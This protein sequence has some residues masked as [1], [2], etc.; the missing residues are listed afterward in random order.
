MAVNDFLFPDDEPDKPRMGGKAYA[1][2]KLGK[3]FP[4]PGWFVVTPQAMTDGALKSHATKALADALDSLGPGP[5]AVRSSAVDEDGSESSFAGQFES[6]LNVAAENVAQKITEVWQSAFT[7]SVLT[8]RKQRGL[9][10][11]PSAPAVLIQKMVRAESAGVAFTA[12]P[13]THDT[14]RIAIMSVKGLADRLV[15]GEENG[16][17]YY[18]D[19]KGKPLSQDLL[20]KK[21]ILTDKQKKQVVELALKAEAYFGCPQDIEWAFEGGKLYL[22][23]SRPITTLATQTE[24]DGDIIIWDNSNIVESYSGVTSPLTFSFARRAYTEVYKSF[25]LLMGVTRRKIEENDTVFSNM[26]GFIYGHVYYNLLNWY[27]LLALYPGFTLNRA[28]MEQMMGVREALPE[29]MAHQIAPSK[30]NFAAK[31]FDIL[32]LSRTFFRLLG[33]AFILKYRVNSFYKRLNR[34]MANPEP[35]L[36]DRN[37]QELGA[38]YRTLEQE[39]LSRWYTPIINDFLCMIAFGVSQ[40]ILKKWC[41]DDAGQS[42]HNDFMIGQ[43]DIISAEPARRIHHMAELARTDEQL[44]DNLIKG[45]IQILDQ[46]PKL[47]QEFDDYIAKFGDRCTQELKLE[48][49]TLD[50]DPQALLQAIGYTAQRPHTPEKSQQITPEKRLDETLHGKPFKKRIARFWVNWAKARIRDRENL[51]FERTRVFGRVRKVFLAAGKRLA[52]ENLIEQERDIFFLQVEEILGLI[53]GTIMTC[54]LKAL[55]A[56]RR[57]EAESFH[58]KGDLPNRFETRGATLPDLMKT[59]LKETAFVSNAKGEKRTGLGCCSGIVKA[60]VRVI[61]DPRTEILQSGEILVAKHTDPGWI[62]LFSNAAGILVERGSLLSHSAIVAREMGIPAIVAIP[63]IMH[64]L[65]NGDIVEMN[66]ATGMVVKVNDE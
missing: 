33:N 66:G 39:L 55:I 16:D 59:N 42:L 11:A 17:T 7:E 32:R 20:G 3:Q 27:R 54:D 35:P 34:V 37:L 14:N 49:L 21:S 41:G 62:A 31:L 48:S 50:E 43:G 24:Q 8:Y 56:L 57:K 61:H 28:F 25:S 38:Y 47:K 1:L 64:W 15:S 40:K 30:N 51:R 45:D 23:Q 44:I 5:F 60:K 53:D 2:A 52:E 46:H 4:I 26:L 22:L 63:D 29:Q 13:L 9:D 36:K 65:K 58:E 19:R 10:T 18:L 6:F 12:D